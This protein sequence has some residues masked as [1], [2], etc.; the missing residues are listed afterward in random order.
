MC[1]AIEA[2]GHNVTIVR[3]SRFSDSLKHISVSDYYGTN[4]AADIVRL[5]HIDLASITRWVPIQKLRNAL[6][7][8][9]GF[10]FARSASRAVDRMSVDIAYV[11]DW[12]VAEA[13]VKRGIPTILEL[14]LVAP[15]NWQRKRITK[16]TLDKNIKLVVAITAGVAS[17]LMQ[18]GV[19]SGKLMVEPDAVDS[20]E[21]GSLPNKIKARVEFELPAESKIAC[22]TGSF[23]GWKGV[24]EIIDAA[25]LSPEFTFVL[26]GGE[27]KDLPSGC[28]RK[29]TSASNIVVLGRLAPLKIPRLQAASDVLLLPNSGKQEIS[30]EFTSP[31]KMFEYMAA[32]RPIVATDLPSLREHLQHGHNSLLVEPDDAAS[33]AGG[34][35]RVMEDEELSKRIATS[36]YEYVKAYSWTGRSSRVLDRAAK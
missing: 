22:Y 27:L 24:G 3:P 1:S 13:L 26:A 29:V 5:R 33:L 21:Y 16:L 9:D 6:L 11:R 25:K 12:E 2:L 31:L 30:S 15:S 19:P 14:H 28:V 18:I 4:L 36:A 7:V 20:K 23:Y 34:I 32:H 8:L 10:L 17:V 35:R